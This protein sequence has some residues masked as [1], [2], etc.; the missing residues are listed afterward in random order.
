[1]SRE[2]YI[3]IQWSLHSGRNGRDRDSLLRDPNELDAK[4]NRLGRE[5]H[6][7]S[8]GIVCDTDSLPGGRR[9]AACRGDGEQEK[10]SHRS[11]EFE[12]HVD[13]DCGGGG[14]IFLWTDG[15]VGPFFVKVLDEG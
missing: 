5:P 1:M 15:L 10:A 13:F 4:R 9:S 8:E 7:R 3:Y 14:G 2:R 11:E 12:L 6:Q